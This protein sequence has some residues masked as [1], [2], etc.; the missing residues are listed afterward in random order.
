MT[1]CG[2]PVKNIAV[3]LRYI[4]S[5]QCTLAYIDSYL[6]GICVIQQHFNIFL[7]MIKGAI[8]E[9]MKA[10]LNSKWLVS[11]FHLQEKF[12]KCS[13]AWEMLCNSVM[14]VTFATKSSVVPRLWDYIFYK[15]MTR[16]L[17]IHVINAQ[18]HSKVV[19]IDS[20]TLEMCMIKT[21]LSNVTFV[22][23]HS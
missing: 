3:L 11:N 15:F 21:K 2:I 22:K 7:G 16:V 9:L 5:S 13:M 12:Q 14:I 4:A 1:F 6:T 23:K 8:K 20:G 17:N 10:M 19:D 18:S